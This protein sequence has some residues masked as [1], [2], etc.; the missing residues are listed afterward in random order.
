MKSDVD[1]LQWEIKRKRMVILDDL[2]LIYVPCRDFVQSDEYKWV[3]E[4]DINFSF[5]LVNL[6]SVQSELQY[7][8]HCNSDDNCRGVGLVQE[9]G[10]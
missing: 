8:R 2:F 3:K 6:G 7:F 5:S 4:N 9:K 10:N 1:N